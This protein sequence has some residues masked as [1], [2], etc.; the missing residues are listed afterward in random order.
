MDA[1]AGATTSQFELT[2][3]QRAIQEMTQGFAADR[4][5]PNAL[6][7]DRERHFPSDV[8][9]ET[10]ALGFG[11]IY[12][13]EDVGGSGLGRM[14]A[15]LIFE[16]LST[17][18]AGFS[19]MISIHN[20][21]AWMIDQF[22]SQEQ[23]ERFLPKMTAL[24]WLASYCL[25][26]PG[27]GSDAAA[28]RTRATKDGDH[29]V[30][31]GTK[32]FISGAG[33]SD[34][35][36]VMAR[37][38]EDGP[39]GI[40]TFVIHKDTPGLSF[41]P[42]ENKMGWHMQPTRQVIFENC[43]V[44][45]ADLLS[46][47]GAGFR[48]AMAGLDGG[49]LNIAACSLGGA[50]SALDKALAYAGERSAF[51][52]TIDQFQSLQFKLADMETELQASRLFLYAAAAKLDRKA[53][54]TGKWSAMAKRFVTDTCFDIANQALQIHGGYGYLHEYGIEKI[55]RDLRVHQILEGTNEIMRVIVARHLIGR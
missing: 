14:D 13:R 50:Q 30:L 32:Q 6:E 8:I 5:A 29:Y 7:W 51:G 4:V 2:E 17:A 54:D 37:T 31:N 47:E 23:R 55:V 38:G 34:I 9:R 43:R 12:V 27:A 18:C 1:A 33:E 22:G 35:Y 41:G 16:A 42:A 52:K 19:S 3:D 25:T 28:L 49:R 39:K 11:G 26:E 53:A 46:G 48:I 20:M 24:E 21:A 10:G 40:S 36:L 44:P 15:V 45:A